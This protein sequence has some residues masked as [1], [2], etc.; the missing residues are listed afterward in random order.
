MS[1]YGALRSRPGQPPRPAR[2]GITLRELMITLAI[3]G[4]LAAIAYPS[5]TSHLRKS[6][7]AE[8]QQVLLDIAARQQQLLLDSRAY[9]ATL[10]DTGAT[11]PASAQASYRFEVAPGTGTTPGFTAIAVPLGAQ[12]ADG[13]GTLSINESNLRTPASCW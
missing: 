5:Y 11:V 1:M 12:V 9:A 7:R 8:A 4:I 6:R 3:V 10:V 13:C 2:R